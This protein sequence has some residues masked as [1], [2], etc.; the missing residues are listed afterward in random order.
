MKPDLKFTAAP[1]RVVLI[2]LVTIT[3]ANAITYTNTGLTA[4]TQYYFIVRA[5]GASGAAVVS[6]EAAAKTEVDNTGLLLL[7]A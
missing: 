1:S 5:V 4:N 3:P 2:R 6:N 7:P